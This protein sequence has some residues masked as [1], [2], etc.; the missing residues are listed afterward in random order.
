MVRFLNYTVFYRSLL[1]NGN[2]PSQLLHPQHRHL[3]LLICAFQ[4]LLVNHIQLEQTGDFPGVRPRHEPPKRRVGQRVVQA[5]VAVVS[6]LLVADHQ[7][8]VAFLGASG[9]R[10]SVEQ[11]ASQRAKFILY[12]LLDFFQF[13]KDYEEA[14]RIKN[15]KKK[16][17]K[18]KKN[19]NLKLF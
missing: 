2:S 10:V 3:F 6:P 11:L 12:L 9:F 4:Y 17:P 13:I 18:A 15:E 5:I 1:P 14:R 19:N 16:K 7:L 8:E